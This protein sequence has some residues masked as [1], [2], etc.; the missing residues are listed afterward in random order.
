MRCFL[1]LVL[2]SGSLEASDAECI[3][4]QA[5]SELGI[6]VHPGPG[7]PGVSHRMA[8]GTMAQKVETAPETGWLHIKA[9]AVGGWIVKRYVGDVVPCPEVETKATGELSEADG[10][11]SSSVA[12]ISSTFMT[13][14]RADF[15][16]MLGGTFLSV[17]SA[18]NVSF[19]PP[20]G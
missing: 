15:Q 1:W 2:A 5:T 10:P 9:S 6:P 13:A 4:L 18:A 3:L 12:G 14:S 19:S 20:H 17:A 11:N 16:K 7:N 8:D